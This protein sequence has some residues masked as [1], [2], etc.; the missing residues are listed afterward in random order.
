M[1][2]Y[3][4]I[5]LTGEKRVGKSTLWKKV[6]AQA[7]IV[8]QGFQTLPYE[9]EGR[10]A[11][12]RLHCLG[13][14]P[15]G[16]H[17]DIPISVHMKPGTHIP[18]PESFELFGTAILTEAAAS[19]G[20]LLMDE[21]GRLERNALCFQQ[22]VLRCLDADCSVLGVLQKTESAFLNHI[23]T[24]PDVLVISVTAEN[25]DSLV[26]PLLEAVSSR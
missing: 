13:T 10:F 3:R 21:L 9:V 15:E 19:G 18:I 1:N 16:F 24:R 23:Q 14:L 7:G 4:H 6:L 17:N 11:G 22:A 5:F 25:R 2:T 8:P 20:I 12:Y 26:R